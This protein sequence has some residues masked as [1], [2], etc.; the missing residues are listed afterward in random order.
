MPALTNQQAIASAVTATLGLVVPFAL[1][2]A[3]IVLAIRAR[4][5]FRQNPALGGKV[6]MSLGLW[7]GIGGLAAWTWVAYKI[8]TR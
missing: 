1:S 3:A 6:L 7:L 4:T 2:I 5:T 8:A